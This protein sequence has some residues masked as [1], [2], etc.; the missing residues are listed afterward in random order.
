MSAREQELADIKAAE[1]ETSEGYEGSRA[2]RNHIG[3]NAVGFKVSSEAET[4]IISVVSG[5]SE[6][7]LVIV[8]LDTPSETIGLEATKTV[9]LDTLSTNLPN[10]SPSYALFRWQ[11]DKIVFIYACPSSSR[12]KDRMVYA[13]GVGAFI[14]TAEGLA[15]FKVFKKL[16]TSDPSDLDITF[17]RESHASLPSSSQ[18]T[19]PPSFARPRGPPRKR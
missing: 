18:G 7:N 1:K 3:N 5:E 2:R 6:N 9:T 11:S 8:G 14:Q 17:T 16:E 12:V 10:S 19:G 15:G 13:S 4:A